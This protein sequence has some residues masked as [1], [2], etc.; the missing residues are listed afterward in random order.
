M[1]KEIKPDLV[2]HT[3][4]LV[5]VDYCEDHA[6]EAW[7]TNVEGAENV[8]CA[9][10]EVVA[11][12]VYISTDSV[13]DGRKGM[14]VEEDTPQPVN[15]YAMTKLEGERRVRCWLPNSMIVRTAFYGWATSSSGKVSLA[16]WI[17]TELKKGEAINL[18]TDVSF[19]P[20]LASNLAEVLVEM[21]DGN[22]SGV[23][24]VGGS[25]RCSKYIFGREI[26]QAFGLDVNLIKPSSIVTAGLRAPRP[27]DISLDSTKVS[28]VINT[29]LLNVKEGIALL[30]DS[31]YSS[32]EERK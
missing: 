12:M 16:Q 11:K 9:S 8:A 29:R 28:R 14:Y 30:R 19:S 20:I 3:A 10:K 2:I 22:V 18:F 7:L 13:F 27:K 15:V 4:A 17:V 23:Y 32:R 25:E 31:A 26:A 6:D 5:D 24:H 1:F 21:Y